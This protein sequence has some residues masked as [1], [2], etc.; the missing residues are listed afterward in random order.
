M[1]PTDRMQPMVALLPEGLWEE[2]AV[3]GHRRNRDRVP[4][5]TEQ[6]GHVRMAQKGSTVP[7]AEKPD[8]GFLFD[9]GLF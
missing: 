9:A 3:L 8:E 6:R 4:E 7:E 1:I 5:L 2:G